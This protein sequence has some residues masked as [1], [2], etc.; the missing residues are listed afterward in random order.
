L[1]TI[2]YSDL[3]DYPLTPEEISHYLIGV[4]CDS[5]T[6]R[7]RLAAPVWL[8]GRIARV[9]GYV[10]LAGREG[11]VR[12]RRERA[13]CSNKIW[14][15]ARAFVRILSCLPFVRM[16]GVTGALSMDNSNEG[17][18]VDV[19]I[20]TAPNRVWM[21]RAISLMIVY[22]GRLGHSTLC[23]NYLL[24]E[25]V[26]PL[27]QR[28]I[29]IAH[30]FV[31]MVPLYGLV[32]YERMRAAN[33]WIEV[34]LP[35]AR[36][37]FHPRAEYNPGVVGR[38]MK[39]LMERCLSGRLGDRFEAWEMRRKLRKFRPQLMKSGGSAVL[40]KDQVKG[41][42]ED[43]GKHVRETYD[44]RLKEFS[45]MGTAYVQDPPPPE[46]ILVSG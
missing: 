3:F 17:D 14:H 44:L 16:V 9:D 35:N 28:N 24:S 37:P 18:D 15:R 38:V 8:Q 45:L 21:V 34:I 10:T 12:K 20:V 40:S 36:E 32:V 43:H 7:A 42:F 11:I 33:P 6:V 41:H 2:L 4:A 39:G 25:E 29:Y 30:E 46:A 1:R 27:Q 26:L 19:I 31:Q 5:E 13:R 22:A 23:P